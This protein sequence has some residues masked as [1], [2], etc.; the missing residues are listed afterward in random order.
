[1]N[2]IQPIIVVGRNRSGTK[3]LSNI[4]CNHSKIVG[5]Q[6]D[7][8][9]GIQ[10]TNMFG[11]LTRKFPDLTYVS[12]YIGLIELWSATDFFK[13]AKGDKVIFYQ[14]RPRP[15]DCFEIFSILMEDLVRR[16][17][18]QFWLQKTDPQDAVAALKAYPDAKCLIIERDF[19]DTMK[20]TL[21]MWTNYGRERHIINAILLFVMQEKLLARLGR[22]R[23]VCRVTYERLRSD[24]TDVVRDVCEYL[25][26]EYE[27]DVTKVTFRKNTSF[28]SDAERSAVLKPSKM[29]LCGFLRGVFSFVPLEILWLLWNLK[30]A[31]KAYLVPG[32]YEMIRRKFDL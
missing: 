1:M 11:S 22:K 27:K 31:R 28:Q 30:S 15:K 29:V 8:G 24:T 19:Y 10:E 16:E 18:A 7:H 26:V 13:I 17:K 21:K 14:M 2:K 32:S 25:G 20:S 6:S 5:V 4:L 23:E 12:D 9:G 3:W